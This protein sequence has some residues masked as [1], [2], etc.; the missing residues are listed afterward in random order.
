[1]VNADVDSETKTQ[2]HWKIIRKTREN[3][4]LKIKECCDRNTS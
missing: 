2:N 3:N 1:M 4:L